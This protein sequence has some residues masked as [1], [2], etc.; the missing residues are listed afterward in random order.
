M[1]EEYYKKG[2][3]LGKIEDYENPRGTLTMPLN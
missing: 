1:S 3:S 2:L